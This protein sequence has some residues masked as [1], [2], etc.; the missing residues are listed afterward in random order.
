MADIGR[1]D[2]AR[3][4]RA[5]CQR[6]LD[7]TRLT[8]FET[9]DAF[10]E[11]SN[12]A[13]EFVTE[14]DRD[15]LAGDGVRV[16]RAEVRPAQVFVQVGA[17]DS[18]VRRLDLVTVSACEVSAGCSVAVLTLTWPGLTVGSATSVSTRMSSLP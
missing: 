5:A 9:R 1:L 11:L 4:T 14:S 13:G 8:D 6:W 3:G 15:G 7:S 12:D 18:Y 2:L 16:D 10:A 17:A